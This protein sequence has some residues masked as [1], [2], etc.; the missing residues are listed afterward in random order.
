M[1][2][3]ACLITFRASAKNASTVSYR[4]S[5][6]LGHPT[7][8]ATITTIQ[9]SVETVLPAIE[10]SLTVVTYDQVHID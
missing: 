7:S 10:S 8:V 9:K 4:H 3:F 6:K 2:G 5:R 1:L